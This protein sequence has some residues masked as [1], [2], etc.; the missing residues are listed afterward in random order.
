MRVVK[1]AE[2]FLVLTLGRWI[3]TSKAFIRMTLTEMN[4]VREW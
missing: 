1:L 4:L 3:L 2:L